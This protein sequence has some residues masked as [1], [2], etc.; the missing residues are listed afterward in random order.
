NMNRRSISPARVG[1]ASSSANAED[2]RAHITPPSSPKPE[3]KAYPLGPSASVMKKPKPVIPLEHEFSSEK[4]V[5]LADIKDDEE[6]VKK[7]AKEEEGEK[8]TF[9]ATA[10]PGQAWEP[11]YYWM[12]DS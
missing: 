7:K 10:Y 5:V 4:I 6:R 2:E 12:G 1:E 9:S 11:E 8:L 3:K